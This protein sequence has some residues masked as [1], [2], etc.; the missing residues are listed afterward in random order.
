MNLQLLMEWV[1]ET[2]KWLLLGAVVG[3]VSTAIGI[4]LG[5]PFWA[6][7]GLMIVAWFACMGVLALGEIK[8]QEME[9]AK[10]KEPQ[11]AVQQ[12]D[13]VQH[14]KNLLARIME[15]MDQAK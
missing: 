1:K 13:M 4:W 3:A 9:I 10:K 6:N 7:W 12:A 5:L 14:A 15:I 2:V 8:K 11:G